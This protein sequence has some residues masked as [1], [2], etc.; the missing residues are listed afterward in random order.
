MTQVTLSA[1]TN[2][3]FLTIKKFLSSFVF[4]LFALCAIASTVAVGFAQKGD[5]VKVAEASNDGDWTKWIMC[6]LLPDP[7]SDIYQ[8]TNTDDL[9]FEF[10]SKSIASTGAQRVD[11]FY[12]SLL[13]I[14]TDDDFVEANE[15]VLGVPLYAKPDVNLEELSD[16]ERDKVEEEKKAAQ[17]ARKKAVQAGEETTSALNAGEPFNPYERFGVAGLTF[18]NYMGEWKYLVVDACANKGE[19]SD[20]D[21]GLMYEDRLAPMATWENRSN[22]FDIR[23]VQST[24]GIFS[25]FM[26][27][28]MNVAANLVFSVTK[29]IVTLTLALIFFS[30]SDVADA[31]GIN[32]LV[33]GEEG[34]IFDSLF[35]GVFSPLIWVVMLA[36][37]IRMFWLG[38]VKR[39]IRKSLG[40]FMLSLLMVLLG[41]IAAAIP[42][43]VVSLPN[44]VATVGQ[45]LVVSAVGGSVTNTEGI[46]QKRS[47]V[48]EITSASGIT[49]DVEILDEANKNIR[50]SIGCQYWEAFLLRPWSEAQFGDNYTKLWAK[51][52]STKLGS[53]VSG[54]EEIMND[55]EE[56]VGKASVPLGGGEFINN[57]AIFQISTQTDAHAQINTAY[58][59][60]T[61]YTS[62][63]ASDIWR[64]VDALANYD[65]ELKTEVVY[66]S[67]EGG[68]QKIQYTEQKRTNVPS[69]YWSQ[70][71]GNNNINR[72]GIAAGSILIA[73]VG[74]AI[75][76][77]FAATSAMLSIAIAIIMSFAPFALL[78]GAWGGK[79]RQFFMSWL[80]LLMN[81]VIKRIVAGLLLIVTIIGQTK[82]LAMN[83]TLSFWSILFAVALFSVIMWKTRDKIFALFATFNFGGNQLQG[84]YEKVAQSSKQQAR[85]GVGV[86]T[87]FAAST[88]GG[89]MGAKAAGGTSFGGIYDGLKYEMRNMALRNE[90]LRQINTQY[91]LTKAK[92]GENTIEGKYCISCGIELKYNEKDRFKGGVV[93]A[94]NYVCEKCYNEQI[95]PDATE[96][97]FNKKDKVPTRK[98]WYDERLDAKN[99]RLRKVQTMHREAFG[100]KKRA[101]G[102]ETQREFN[103]LEKGKKVVGRNGQNMQVPFSNEEKHRMA[104]DIADAIKF[105]MYNFRKQREDLKFAGD[106]RRGG[107]KNPIPQI[108]EQLKSYVDTNA[109]KQAWNGE[110]YEYLSH[111]YAAGISGYIK[112]NSNSEVN[113]DADRLAQDIHSS[114]DRG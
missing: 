68:I 64:I 85:R 6:S 111:M 36:T 4:L 20:P 25:H 56:M 112:D 16:E 40:E 107:S 45:A 86:A 88:A 13:T 94:G 62:G 105:D 18:S 114:V 21:A 15:S 2:S 29:F 50:A 72:I 1:R 24:R 103:N 28:F 43:K 84:T 67:E 12:N 110:D 92:T 60:P 55:N 95:F 33:G 8:F 48:E 31:I 54:A 97:Y 35:N 42:Q 109:M 23:V 41:L 104:F 79:G 113:I 58:G 91:E 26:S 87:N 10:R 34:G 17:E 98:G 74:V 38:A 5:V 90:N 83:D 37:A 63:I 99:Q 27:S 76:L 77:L 52:E 78:A 70:W 39:Q 44:D 53:D 47:G 3:P 19:P 100:E 59:D 11:N 65:E 66:Q 57:W 81:A 14:G 49:D 69:E 93:D 75:P 7:A 71:V 61:H 46:C 51:G 9:P 89:A 82:I 30:F 106:G 73:L 108:P 96:V 102:F 22:S 101:P 80:S 32:D